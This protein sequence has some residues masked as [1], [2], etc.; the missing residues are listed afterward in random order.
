MARRNAVQM[1]YWR[2][3]EDAT[4]VRMV[5]HSKLCLFKGRPNAGDITL[6]GLASVAQPSAV[7]EGAAAA[8]VGTVGG[9]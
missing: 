4:G 7:Q 2:S 6:G 5:K 9:M 1:V 8:A 3:V